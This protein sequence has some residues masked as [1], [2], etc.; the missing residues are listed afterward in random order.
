MRT[1]LANVASRSYSAVTPAK[2]GGR[3]GE[4][5]ITERSWP[6]HT[7]RNAPL[8]FPT[9]KIDAEQRTSWWKQTLRDL[10][11]RATS[12]AYSHLSSRRIGAA[13]ICFK[14]PSPKSS[15]PEPNDFQ[16]S[17]STKGRGSTRPERSRRSQRSAIKGGRTTVGP[18]PLSS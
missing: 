18:P 10:N 8:L 1:G 16:A 7:S 4:A 12:R 14:S 9:G 17:S 5:A 13:R 11:C 15:A 6:F 2:C 3:G